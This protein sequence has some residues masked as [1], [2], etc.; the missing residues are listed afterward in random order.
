M[1]DPR[2]VK[3]VYVKKTQSSGMFADFHNDVATYTKQVS[4]EQTTQLLT[5]LHN[6]IQSQKETIGKYDLASDG[7][8]VSINPDCKP[9]LQACNN[10]F[11]KDGMITDKTKTFAGKV[12]MICA[13]GAATGMSER[14]IFSLH[15][16]IPDF[17]SYK[18]CREKMTDDEVLASYMTNVENNIAKKEN[19]PRFKSQCSAATEFISTHRSELTATSATPT[20]PA[21]QSDYGDLSGMQ[22]ALENAKKLAENKTADYGTMPTSPE[23]SIER[24]STP[25]PPLTAEDIAYNARTS[26]DGSA[27]MPE[28]FNPSNYGNVRGAID[29]PDYGTIPTSLGTDSSSPAAPAESIKPGDGLPQ[30]FNPSNYGNVRGAKDTSD[31]GAIPAPSEATS[32]RT[33]EYGTMAAAIEKPTRPVPALPADGAVE[34][35]KHFIT[36]LKQAIAK[37]PDTKQSLPGEVMQI[38]SELQRNIDP[39]E[40]WQNVNA[41][42]H[43][44][45]S[46]PESAAQDAKSQ[47]TRFMDRAVKNPVAALADM[48]KSINK[49]MKVQESVKSVTKSADST[50]DQPA[51]ATPRRP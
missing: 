5:S 45:L 31:Y 9:S 16:K 3:N 42:L 32:S 20:G 38:E 10:E 44:Q 6:S 18:A 51:P 30:G 26:T 48:V 13:L 49:D 39:T 47:A 35:L 40:K 46:K 34:K 2:A 21:K 24:P 29:T 25:P 7:K 22:E 15:E 11:L 19:D 33:H 8:S 1:A 27:R 14:E 41:R 12:A 4:K 37:S 50:P 43:E 28:G 36:N 17:K 23:I